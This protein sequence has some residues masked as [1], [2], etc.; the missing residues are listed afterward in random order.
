MVRVRVV[1]HEEHHIVDDRVI[2]D[3]VD[4]TMVPVEWWV[5]APERERW[6][7]VRMRWQCQGLAIFLNSRKPR[8]QQF[9][10]VQW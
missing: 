9:S 3:E 1:P 10:L 2:Q 8:I 7:D 4:I 6:E 5:D